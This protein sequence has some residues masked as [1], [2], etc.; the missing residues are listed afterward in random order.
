MQVILIQLI[1]VSILILLYPST[2]TTIIIVLLL[3]DD[4]PLHDLLLC[5]DLLHDR[6][7]SP[8]EE[9][10]VAASPCMVAM[11]CLGTHQV[12]VVVWELLL[13]RVEVIF[14]CQ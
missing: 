5:D 8:V 4:E 13:R 1:S 14:V 10:R 6:A 2:T 7:L 11:R 9:V 3:C 12:I